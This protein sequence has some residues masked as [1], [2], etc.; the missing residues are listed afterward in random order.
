MGQQNEELD[1]IIGYRITTLERAAVK[2]Q[3]QDYFGCC[4]NPFMDNFMSVI[5]NRQH[6]DIGKFDEWLHKKFGDYEAKGE[7]MNMVIEEHFGKEAK[8]FIDKLS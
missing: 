6:I 2:K 5:L 3:F 4:I 1:T 8:E 7:S